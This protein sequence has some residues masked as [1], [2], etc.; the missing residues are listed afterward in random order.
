MAHRV[1]THQQKTLSGKL[2][3]QKSHEE[4]QASRLGASGRSSCLVRPEGLEPPTF[5]L[6]V[7]GSIQLS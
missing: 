1:L 5:G 7:R 3:R 4:G 6:E 2:F